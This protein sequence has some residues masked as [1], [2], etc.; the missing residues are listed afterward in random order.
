MAGLAHAARHFDTKRGVPFDRY[1]ATRVRGAILDELRGF[2][3]ASRPV[4]TKAR[5]L[6]NLAE[7][8][9]GVLGRTPTD[10]ELANA[11]GLDLKTLR[12]FNGD[13]HRSV[14][15]N[16]EAMV[17]AGGAEFL[18]PAANDNPEEELLTTER[19]QFLAAAMR[20]LPE[21][22]QTVI[23]G[24]FFEER[25]VC[26]L[27]EQLGVTQSRISQLRTEALELLRDGM[28]S[29]LDPV[30]VTPLRRPSV[31]RRHAAYRAAMAEPHTTAV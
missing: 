3:W 6:T 18:L 22:L 16:Y 31:S 24:Y 27:S 12:Q 17:E 9:T 11:A 30:N 21:R 8:L 26:E 28:S 1:A 29:Q 19:V 5:A 10:V 7:S 2:D 13:L 20:A 25:S 4:R 14:V 23:R 15:L